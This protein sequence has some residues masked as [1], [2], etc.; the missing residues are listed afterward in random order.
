VDLLAG[1]G[2]LVL[3]KSDIEVILVYWHL[4]IERMLILRVGVNRYKIIFTLLTIHQSFISTYIIN[5]SLEH[6]NS[7]HNVH[8]LTWKPLQEKT[9]KLI[10]INLCGTNLLLKNF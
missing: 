5:N 10:F 4:L 3:I 9:I 6:I 2:H 8:S 7:N 1:G